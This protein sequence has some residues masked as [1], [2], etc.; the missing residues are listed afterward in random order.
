MRKGNVVTKVLYDGK[1][2]V[3][4][5][6]SETQKKKSVIENLLKVKDNRVKRRLTFNGEVVNKTL[7]EDH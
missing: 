2:E 1:R 6:R 3:V 4:V 5:Q 7:D